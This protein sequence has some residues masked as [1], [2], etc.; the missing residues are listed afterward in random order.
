[1]MSNDLVDLNTY[2]KSDDPAND[3]PY[4]GMLENL[5]CN[6]LKSHGREHAAHLFLEFTADADDVKNWIQDF[7]HRFV[8]PARKQLLDTKA[9]KKQLS[10]QES[11]RDGELI[12]SFFLSAQGYEP[13]GFGTEGFEESFRKGMKDR[14]KYTFRGSLRRENKDPSPLKWELPYR[15]NIHAMILLAHDHEEELKR[16]VNEVQADVARIAHVLT[17]E[18]GA[19]LRNNNI[20][21]NSGKGQAIEHFGYVDGRSQPVFLK[22]D[23]DE[24]RQQGGSDMWNPEAPL[25]LVLCKDPC[26]DGVPDCYGSYLVFRKLE[27]NVGWFRARA[28]KLAGELGLTGEEAKRAGALVVGRFQDGT[29]L[30]LKRTDGMDMRADR[31]GIRNNFTYGKRPE[32]Q[33]LDPTGVQPPEIQGGDPWGYKCPYHAHVRKVNPRGGA[34]GLSDEEE[35]EHRIV[36]RGIPY[37][38]RAADLSD[39]PTEGVGLLFLCYQS[40]IHEQFEFLQR[41]WADDPEFPR[42]ALL[43]KQVGDDALIGQD[44]KAIQRQWPKTWGTARQTIDFN[45]GG[46]ITLKGGEYFFAPSLSFLKNIARL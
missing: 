8:T 35:R 12:G 27:Q 15:G 32:A 16:R 42:V 2:V 29:P 1:M 31:G 19:V 14:S 40:N 11:A 10:Q 20:Q 4:K 6:I 30:T 7:A 26:A 37:G 18:Y 41:V 36:R 17:V 24:E 38:K 5:Q 9:R 28:R 44:S 3:E 13:L 25:H 22:Q 39:S 21:P 33:K 23:T 45:F 34:P 43:Q 46:Y